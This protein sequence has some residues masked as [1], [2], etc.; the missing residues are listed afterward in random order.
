MNELVQ[1]LVQKTG[2]SPEKAQ[3]IVDT[4]VSHLKARLP[5]P[6]AS[7]LDSV[8]SSGGN[9]GELAAIEEKAK[10]MTAGLGSAFG[11]KQ[12]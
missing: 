2:I 3:E 4:V 8:L 10:S 1:L 9:A 5:G 12:E 7:H 11:K 6:I